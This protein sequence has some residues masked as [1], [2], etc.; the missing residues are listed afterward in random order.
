MFDSAGARLIHV[1]FIIT[2]AGV[3]G[4]E[5]H[6]ISLAKGLDPSCFQVSLVYLKNETD[7]L[8]TIDPIQI[9]GAIFCAG[10]INKIDIGAIKRIAA[11]IRS[12]SVDILV[13]ANL[14]PLSYAWA[15]RLTSLRKPYIVEVL[16]STEPLSPRFQLGM[17]VYR[18]LL[19]ISDAVIYVCHNQRR[20][21]RSRRL[22]ARHEEVIHN[23]VDADHFVNDFSLPRLSEFRQHYGLLPN[24]YV[25]GLCGYMRPEKAHRDLL[26]AIVY[27]R[28]TGLNV[29]CL[30]IGD[31]PERP[32][33]E[34]DIQ[35]LGICAHVAIT[36]VIADVRLAICSC[37]VMV[38]ASHNETFSIAALESMALHRPI[39]MSDVGGAAEQIDNAENGY[40]YKKGDIRSLANLIILLSNPILREKLGACARASVSA[41]FSSRRMIA[42]YSQLFRR[43]TSTQDLPE[44]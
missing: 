32:T 38:I 40:L 24:D 11:H 9:N 35:D 2:S 27:A 36:G 22:V 44:R 34:K 23:G 17:A 28:Q 10:V 19:R 3:G 4:A 21:W 8:E 25:V 7:L 1:M 37:D 39:I 30:L 18:P 14:F 5:T 42:G 29:K 15:A 20:Y 43:L 16:H 26:E 33:I 13:C 12:Q 6:T 41:R 31:G